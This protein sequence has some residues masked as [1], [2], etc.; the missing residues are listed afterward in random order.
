MTQTVINPGDVK[1]IKK[2]SADL[3]KDT[4]AQS[5][6]TQR[7]VG[8]GKNFVIQQKT[9]LESDAGDTIQFD[10]AVQLR[11]QPTVGDERL[12]GKEEN[13]RFFS[14]Q[15]LIDQLRKGV[16]AGGKMTRKR[17]LHDLRAL[18]KE[19]LS[20]YWAKWMDE[21]LFIYLSGARGINQDYIQPLDWTGHAGNAIQA[22]DTAHI[23]YAGSATSKATVTSADKMSRL[24]IERAQT[25]VT[26]IRA[27]NPD[28]TRMMPVNVNGEGRYV[29]I[30]SPQDAFN[31]RTGDTAGWIDMNKQLIAGGDKANPIFKG[32]LGMLANTV[33]HSHESAVRFSDYGAGVNLP[34]S[35]SLFMG[36]QAAVIAYGT[37]A[38]SR[39]QWIEERDDYG[40]LINA[41]SGVIFGVKKTRWNSKDFGVVA[42]DSYSAAVS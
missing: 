6:F 39:F 18:S 36:K 19:M 21:A 22:P 38:G 13:L 25:Y 1:A 30:M 7:F 31:L 20:E 34:A 12:K 35:R 26:M 29:L 40:N 33:L 14:D 37:G 2:W 9:E 28:A 24:F 23:M 11:G 3:A 15:V 5:Y 17:V 41:A 8:K 16:S 32:G 42:L 4:N 27:V 10:L